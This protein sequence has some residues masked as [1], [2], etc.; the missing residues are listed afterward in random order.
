MNLRERKLPPNGRLFV[1]I[2]SHGCGRCARILGHRFRTSSGNIPSL[3]LIEPYN[4]NIIY[5]IYTLFIPFVVGI[6]TER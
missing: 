4:E 1:I 3:L 2:V 5:I 6:E